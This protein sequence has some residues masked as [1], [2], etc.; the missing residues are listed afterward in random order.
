MRL[1]AILINTAGL[2]FTSPSV[3]ILS[4]TISY[5]FPCETFTTSYCFP[6]LKSI[7][8]SKCRAGAGNDP[9]HVYEHILAGGLGEYVEQKASDKH[10][11]GENA[12]FSK[13]QVLEGFKAI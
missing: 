3:T 12:L 2:N 11:Y 6:V 7:Y 4:L 9:E 1:V 10:Q 8:S 5:S 13:S